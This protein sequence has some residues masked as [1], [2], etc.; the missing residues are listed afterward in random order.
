MTKNFNKFKILA[1]SV[2]LV[3]HGVAG[4]GLSHMTMMAIEPPKVVPPLEIEM[5]TLNMQEEAELPPVTLEPVPTQVA[6]PKSVAAP[7]PPKNTLPK[8]EPKIEP[9]KPPKPKSEPKKE[10]IRQDIPKPQEVKTPDVDIITQQQQKAFEIQQQ[11]QREQEK[12]QERQREQ[13][14]QKEQERLRKEQERQ[15][16]EARKQR[17]IDAENAR[18]AQEAEKARKAQQEAEDAKKRAEQGQGK[19]GDGKDVKTNNKDKGDKDAKTG[20]DKGADTGNKGG[21]SGSELKGQSLSIS[22]ASWERRPN[23]SNL[24]S[25]KISGSA[26][27]TATLTIDVSGR[28]TAVSGVNT[29]DKSLDRQIEQ[30]IRRA[31]LKPFKSANGQPMSGTASFGATVNF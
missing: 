8:P 3:L 19:G 12:E 13:E 26:S 4:Y 27:F 31:K 21:G 20:N 25:D 7:A 2:A 11:K 24:S 17:E 23:W 10:P 6:P 18:R 16:E 15:Q 5:I 30:A 22:N 29:G 9:V 28:I 14:R 1:L